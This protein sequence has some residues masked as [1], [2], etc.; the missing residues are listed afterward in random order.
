MKIL[1]WYIPL[2]LACAVVGIYGGF[3][4]YVTHYRVW[5]DLVEGAAAFAD[6]E[7]RKE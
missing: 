3:N 5:N 7:Q 4:Y 2:L 1:R 6:E